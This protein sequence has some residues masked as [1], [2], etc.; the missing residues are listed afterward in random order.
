VQFD[1]L[2]RNITRVVTLSMHSLEAVRELALKAGASHFFCK[3]EDPEE[4]IA[5]VRDGH[6]RLD[7]TESS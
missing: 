4:L 3:D 1:D 6:Q 2:P 5:T 7:P